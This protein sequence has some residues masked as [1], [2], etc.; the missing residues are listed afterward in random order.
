[1]LRHDGGTDF[2][3]ADVSPSTFFR[4]FTNK[5]ALLI[6]DQLMDP[7]IDVF[8]NAPA[9]LS[10]VAAYRLAVGQMFTGINTAHGTRNGP[11]R[12]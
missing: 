7:I 4:Y 9:E 1:L 11:A 5:E 2:E 12:T 6:P 10:P 3:A 8:I